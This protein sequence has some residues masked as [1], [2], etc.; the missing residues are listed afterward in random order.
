MTVTVH[1]SPK[2][3]FDP[4]T[5]TWVADHDMKVVLRSLVTALHV[6]KN[7]LYAQDDLP[8]YKTH[9][10]YWLQA[11]STKLRLE[12][13]VGAAVLKDIPERVLKFAPEDALVAYLP[14]IVGKAEAYKYFY[15]GKPVSGAP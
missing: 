15:G 3:K 7:C 4:K 5:G 1:L 6:S 13:K 12:S 9:A 10:T 11:M 2:P 14:E 8:T